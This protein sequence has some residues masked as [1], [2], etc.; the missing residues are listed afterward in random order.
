VS[1]I[2]NNI[3]SLV[4]LGVAPYIAFL[5]FPVFQNFQMRFS[6]KYDFSFSNFKMLYLSNGF[7]VETRMRVHFNRNF[8]QLTMVHITILIPNLGPFTVEGNIYF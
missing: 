6:Q 7:Q 8:M 5:S 4:L 3:I 2:G 1:L